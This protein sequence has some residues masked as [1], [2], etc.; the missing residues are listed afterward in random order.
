MNNDP[1]KHVAAI[2][3]RIFEP[4]N[5]GLRFMGLRMFTPSRDS[6]ILDIGCGTGL[7]L[8]MYRNFGCSLYGI[9]TS[10]SMLEKAKARLGKN[11]DLRKAD[12][13]EIPFNSDFFDLVLCML[14]LHEMDDNIRYNVLKEM[15]RVVKQN[16]RVL[17]IDFHAGKARLPL[18]SLFKTII[19]ISEF[20]AGSRHFRNYRQFMSSGGLPTLI[21]RSQMKIEKK[22]ITDNGTMALYLV[23][24]A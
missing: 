9:D 10:P 3:D 17:V 11:V 13:T 12:A 18:G 21:D 15:H 4:M 24:P 8:E 14:V 7:H 19:F 6:S 1:Y 5:K 20:S 23:V 22:K 16:G 2:Y